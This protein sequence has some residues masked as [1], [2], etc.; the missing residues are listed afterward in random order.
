MPFF[1]LSK[2]SQRSRR[3]KKTKELHAINIRIFNFQKNREILQFI[4]YVSV[5]TALKISCLFFMY[6]TKI[7]HEASGFVMG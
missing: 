4:I 5:T 2:K 1:G 7:V 6:K 3:N